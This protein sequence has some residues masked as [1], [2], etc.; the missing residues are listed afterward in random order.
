MN[1]SELK[2][3]RKPDET[4]IFRCSKAAN[5]VFSGGIR[6]KFK[7][8]HAFMYVLITYKNEDLLKNEGARVVT[9]YSCILDAQGQ[10]TL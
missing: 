8:I 1:K 3:Q 4:I 9:L 7:L 10:L 6:P 2:L 5:S